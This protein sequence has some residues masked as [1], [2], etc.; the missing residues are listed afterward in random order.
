M[1]KFY[2]LSASNTFLKKSQKLANMSNLLQ[3]YPRLKNIFKN[4]GIPVFSND[5]LEALARCKNDLLREK[6]IKYQ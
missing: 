6:L 1:S 4:T 5:R 2:T 3:I